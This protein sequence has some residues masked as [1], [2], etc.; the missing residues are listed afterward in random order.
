MVKIQFMCQNI[1]ATKTEHCVVI[2]YA[3]TF[4]GKDP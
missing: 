1:T 4:T 2:K 3:G